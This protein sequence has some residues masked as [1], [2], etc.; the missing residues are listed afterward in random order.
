MRKFWKNAR[1]KNISER[2]IEILRKR[3]SEEEAGERKGEEVGEGIDVRNGAEIGKM[4][5]NGREKEILERK[6]ELLGKNESEKGVGEGRVCVR[7]RKGARKRRG[8][9]RK[10]EEE[11]K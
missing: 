11:L 1:E 10:L 5:K 9:E 6:I 3:G 4:R 2:K 8:K 7:W